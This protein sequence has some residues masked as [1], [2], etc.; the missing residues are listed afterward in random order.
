MTAKYGNWASPADEAES[1][2][3]SDG[4]TMEETRAL[5]VGV[6]GNVT[7]VMAG[8]EAN[9]VTFIGVPT[10]AVLPVSVTSVR[11]TSTTA[12]SIVALR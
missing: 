1:V 7:V 3:P 9:T 10:G 12:S 11:A 8:P 6:G 2:T 5:Y 4:M